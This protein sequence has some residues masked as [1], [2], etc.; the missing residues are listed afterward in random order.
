MDEF[1]KTRAAELTW[2]KFQELDFEEAR[3]GEQE[4]EKNLEAVLGAEMDPPSFKPANAKKLDKD[5]QQA[6]M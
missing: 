3:K 5:M 1:S 4:G 6:L 2:T